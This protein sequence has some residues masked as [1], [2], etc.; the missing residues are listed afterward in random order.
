MLHFFYAEE[1]DGFLA[2]PRSVGNNKEWNFVL[3]VYTNGTM[4]TGL[5]QLKGIWVC[6]KW[7][8]TRYSDNKVVTG[9]GM[10]GWPMLPDETYNWWDYW[11]KGIQLRLDS[12]PRPAEKYLLGDSTGTFQTMPL[13]SGTTYSWDT[14]DATYYWKNCDPIRHSGKSVSVLVDGHAELFSP[15]ECLNSIVLQ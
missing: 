12:L 8:R 7:K 13:R 4:V 14:S 9:Y 3:S 15:D 1:N 11:N 5:K 10:N 6:P 2:Q